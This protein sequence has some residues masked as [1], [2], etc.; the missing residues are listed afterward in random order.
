MNLDNNLKPSAPKRPLS[1]FFWFCKDES[2]KITQTLE[3][4]AYAD[5]TSRQC[6]QR[7]M[8]A[9]PLVKAKYEAVAAKD[10]ARYEKELSQYE[11][12]VETSGAPNG[13]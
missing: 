10:Q 12:Q 5:E 13:D 8:E 1:A 3:P 9:G 11:Q 4:G 6:A 2:D 7:W